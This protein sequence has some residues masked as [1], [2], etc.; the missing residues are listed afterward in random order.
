MNNKRNRKRTILVLLLA[1]ALCAGTW[2]GAY[3]SALLCSYAV[4]QEEKD[5]AQK[6]A[7]EAR[8]AAD[9]K[10]KEAKTP[11]KARREISSVE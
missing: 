10:K 2:Y 6:E 5:Q 7:D 3:N 4:S 9:A 8:A 11:L 1:L